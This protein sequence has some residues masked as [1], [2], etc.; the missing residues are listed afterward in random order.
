MSKRV[1]IT[2]GRD[3]RGRI[4]ANATI[5]GAA[6]QAYL[7]GDP[8]ELKGAAGEVNASIKV[9]SDGGGARVSLFCDGER[10]T[11]TSRKPI[12]RNREIRKNTDLERF[13]K[14]MAF[15]LYFLL[16]LYLAVSSGRPIKWGSIYRVLFSRF[17]FLRQD[18]WKTL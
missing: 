10:A 6:V 9:S 14:V 1:Q 17:Q 15:I 5:E 13:S 16:N 18:F 7:D 3:W 4:Y 11:C 8:T 12:F 2:V